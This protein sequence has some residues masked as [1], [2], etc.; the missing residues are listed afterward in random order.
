MKRNLFLYK[1]QKRTEWFRHVQGFIQK[2]GVPLRLL[3][4]IGRISWES[5]F[6]KRQPNF[7]HLIQS[8]R[9]SR[10][11][12]AEA[13]KEALRESLRWGEAIFSK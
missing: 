12:C 2:T 10:R 13:H 8:T 7:C 6:F 1:I 4:P 11:L 9:F 5:E 3:N